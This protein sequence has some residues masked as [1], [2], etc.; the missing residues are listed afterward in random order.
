MLVNH[1]GELLKNS[2]NWSV[3]AII[4]RKQFWQEWCYKTANVS[5][6]QNVSVSTK[7]HSSITGTPG[8]TRRAVKL[9]RAQTVELSS[10][11]LWPVPRALRAR[12]QLAGKGNV[13]PSV[14]PTG[15]GRRSRS[16][17]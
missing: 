6:H 3:L 1:T 5:S 11:A 12:C 7:E 8:I 4:S 13:V 14:W 2:K 16:S 15:P 17:K 9:A 10:V